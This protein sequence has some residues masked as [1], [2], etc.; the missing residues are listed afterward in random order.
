MRH[1][2]RFV[3]LFALCLAALAGVASEGSPSSKRSDPAALAKLIDAE[4]EARLKDAQIPA[5]ATCSDAEFIR[6]ATLDITGTLPT[7]ERVRAFLVDKKSAKRATL[8]DELLADSDYGEYFGAIWFDLLVVPNDDNRGMISRAFE[9]WLAGQFNAG[10]SWDKIVTAILTADGKRDDNPATVFWFANS[11]MNA[12]PAHVK[13]ADAVGKI[14]QRFLGTQFQCAECHDHPFTP[15][16]QSDFWGTAA[17]FGAL[18]LK[19]AQKKMLKDNGVP[20]LYEKGNKGIIEIPDSKNDTATTH[21]PDGTAFDAK[22]ASGSLRSVFAKWCT[23]PE[24]EQFSRAMVN[25]MWAHFCGRGF[26]MPVDDFRKNNPPSHPEALA[27]LAQDFTASGFDIKH[28]IR[29]I[30]ATLAYQRGSETLPGNKNDESL[31]SHAPLKM[32]SAS[33]LESALDQSLGNEFSDSRAKGKGARAKRKKNGGGKRAVLGTPFEQAFA[34]SEEPDDPEY[35]HGVPQV[36]QLMNGGRLSG[37]PL[38]NSVNRA[39]TPKEAIEH[40]YLATLSRLPAEKEFSR[41][42][43]FVEGAAGKS[44]GYQGVLWALLNSSEYVLN[45]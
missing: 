18:S 29:G 36:L 39:A 42:R 25:R 30:C 12:K 15:L 14:T 45:H 26:V 24:N 38:L 41:M 40:L 23:A 8:V 2:M 1:T 32:M 6:R 16:K 34:T 5:S 19:D 44:A 31:F 43:T 37:S 9:P 4:I 22:S 33:V 35:S 11:D 13:T 21:F 20:G 28:L 7:V 17:F 27:A 10:K 3:S